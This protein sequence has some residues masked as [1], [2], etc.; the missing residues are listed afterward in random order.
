VVTS[1]GAAVTIWNELFGSSHPGGCNFVMGDG[2]VRSIRFG[3]DPVVF[4]AA[5]TRARGEVVNLD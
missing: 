3:I 4:A 2:S 5:C 1:A